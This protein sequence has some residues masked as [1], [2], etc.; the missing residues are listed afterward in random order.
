[1]KIPSEIKIGALRVAVKEVPLLISERGHGGECSF[2]M[3]EI[4]LDPTVPED[5]KTEVLLHEIIEAIDGYYDMG[6]PHY[7]ISTLAFALHQVLA[8]NKLTF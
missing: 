8:D 5:K 2:M 6:L 1:M 4:R 7:Q 3:Q